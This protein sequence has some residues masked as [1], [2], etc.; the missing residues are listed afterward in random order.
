V[1]HLPIRGGSGGGRSG[2]DR[3]HVSDKPGRDELQTHYARPV[4]ENILDAAKTQARRHPGDH[5]R[6]GGIAA[7]LNGSEIQELR[8]LVAVLA[9]PEVAMQE[10]WE[11][12]GTP[13][14]EFP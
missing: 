7:A 12:T 2:H 9:Q 14:Y 8:L 6:R 3:A 13:Q 11:I 10:G 5:R 4:E 1:I